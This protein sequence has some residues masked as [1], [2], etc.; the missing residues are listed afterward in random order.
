LR[1]HLH[2]EGED[3]DDALE[4][5]SQE[6][7]PQGPLHPVT[8]GGTRHVCLGV[9]EVTRVVTVISSTGIKLRG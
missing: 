6:Q 3:G 9:R 2:A 7:L 4:D 1:G 5:H 8:R